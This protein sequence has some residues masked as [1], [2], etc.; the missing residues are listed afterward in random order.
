MFEIF[1]KYFFIIFFAF[2]IYNKLLN[3]SIHAKYQFLLY[4]LS[5]LVLSGVI[6]IFRSLFSYIGLTLMVIPFTII[7]TIYTRTEFRLS[8]ITAILA[9]GIS[10]S[11]FVISAMISSI[12]L[13]IIG[14]G[15]ISKIMYILL[16]SIIL[17]FIMLILLFR[18]R[19]LKNGMPFLTE[20]A[21][22]RTGTT[23][24]ILAVCSIVTLINNDGTSFIYIL[25]FTFIIVCTVY[26]VIWWQ[27]WLTNTYLKRK[28]DADYLA[29][30]N[31]LKERDEYIEKLKQQNSA[32]GKLI[33]QDNKLIPAM[34]MAII[35]LLKSQTNNE[36]TELAETARKLLEDLKGLSNSRKGILSEIEIETK[37]LP[38]TGIS[39]LDSLFTYLSAKATRAKVATDLTV[40][41]NLKYFIQTVIS[42]SDL[43]TLLAEIIDNS[44]I[45]ASYG[46]TKRILISIDLIEKQYVF[47][48]YD[49]G[50]YFNYD[51]LRY[52]GLKQIT[53]RKD[54]GGSG[55]GL[56]N[57]YEIISK[58]KASIIL[59]ETLP[60]TGIYTKRTSVRFDQKN[61]YI[62]KTNRNDKTG[63]LSAR[64]DLIVIKGDNT[65]K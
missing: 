62:L 59:D 22:D 4:S 44:I 25:P 3:L 31:T 53:T 39:S 33:H 63:I 30:Q 34:E 14:L 64:E 54:E 10:N 19:R 7:I 65:S 37:H 50:D 49:S 48:I 58:Y 5:S 15:S 20:N 47:Q 38:V 28:R 51:V 32:L 18:I 12:I 40:H 2:Y 13:Y 52:F 45:S 27:K 29:L 26:I 42:E 9:W 41:A 23:I 6:T 21:T 46:T 8:L 60:S 17:E 57:I 43:N 55:V 56:L 24:A 16:I 35:K 1:I 61:E 36:S 11:A